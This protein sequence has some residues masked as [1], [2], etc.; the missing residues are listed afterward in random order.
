M[1]Q[2]SIYNEQN[3]FEVDDDD[4]DDDCNNSI[5]F[6]QFFVYLRADSTAIGL[7]QSQHGHI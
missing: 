4:N 6:F 3:I 2:Q 5:Q 7:S 1:Q